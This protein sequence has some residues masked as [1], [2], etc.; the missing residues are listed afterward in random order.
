[1][2]NLITIRNSKNDNII[3]KLKAFSINSVSLD[4]K[5]WCHE[6]LIM[7]WKIKT[8]IKQKLILTY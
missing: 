2:T 5:S 1:M 6:Y 7:L 4:H 3:I 8:Q